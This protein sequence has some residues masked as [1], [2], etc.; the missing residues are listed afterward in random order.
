MLSTSNDCTEVHV[1]HKLST[2]I[3]VTMGL[4]L[5]TVIVETNS[6][7]S[8][9]I[10]DKY[11]KMLTI[12][13]LPCFHDMYMVEKKILFVVSLDSV[14]LSVCSCVQPTYLAWMCFSMCCICLWGLLSLNCIVYDWRTAG[15]RG[16]SVSACPW[17]NGQAGRKLWF[18][19]EYS[20]PAC[21]LMD[22]W[23]WQEV[24]EMGGSPCFCADKPLIPFNK[25]SFPLCLFNQKSHTHNHSLWWHT[26]L[27]N[28]SSQPYSN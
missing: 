24:K 23:R 28:I 12:Q 22:E 20:L 3:A 2:T 5:Q 14:A 26:A 1:F 6:Y 21:S 8:N 9:L 7:F 15:L 16:L 11:I 27:T 18:N 17:H 13:Y 10:K 4:D 25:L 19:A